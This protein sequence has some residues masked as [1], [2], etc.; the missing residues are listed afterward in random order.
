MRIRPNPNTQ[1]TGTAPPLPCTSGTL[2]AIAV[3]PTNGNERRASS[4]H[5]R[6]RT[7]SLFNENTNLQATKTSR[8][9]RTTGNAPGPK[10]NLLP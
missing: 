3:I 10:T 9:V 1:I 4:P 7:R 8:K 2:A 5:A 6:A